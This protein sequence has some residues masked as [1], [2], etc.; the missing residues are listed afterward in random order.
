MSMAVAASPGIVPAM[1]TADQPDGERDLLESRTAASVHGATIHCTGNAERSCVVLLQEVIIRK[2]TTVR[3]R[4]ELR[5][6]FPTYECYFAAG[7][8]VDVG[9]DGNDRTL[10]EYARSKAQN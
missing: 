6:M 9:N 8:H 2:G 7:S 3:V 5:H 4:R 1:E 10:I